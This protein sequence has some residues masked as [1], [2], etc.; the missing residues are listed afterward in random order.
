MRTRMQTIGLDPQSIGQP[1][2]FISAYFDICR[3]SSASH[4]IVREVHN[5]SNGSLRGLYEKSYNTH[6]AIQWQSYAMRNNHMHNKYMHNTH[7]H[8][9]NMHYNDMHN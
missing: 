5:T 6:V 1:M 9:N 3:T 2:T 4:S 8:N 7:M